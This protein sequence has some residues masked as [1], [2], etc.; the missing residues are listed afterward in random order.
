MTL[1]PTH[2]MLY[3]PAKLP[4]MRRIVTTKI[5]PASQ[6]PKVASLP[7]NTRSISGSMKRMKA[8]CM[9]ASSATPSTP[10]TN[11]AR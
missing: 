11:I 4:V 7:T 9:L 3:T 1:R 8:A 6:T 2:S 10:T 5:T